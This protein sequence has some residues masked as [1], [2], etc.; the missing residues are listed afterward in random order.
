MKHHHKKSF[1][2]FMGVAGVATLTLFVAAFVWLNSRPITHTTFGVTFS[3]V[4]AQELHQDP[5]DLYEELIDDLKVRHVR[6]P[7]YWSQIETAQDEFD[8]KMPDAL[9]ALSEDRGVQLTIAVGIKVPRW[10][11]CYIPDWVKTQDVTK[12]NQA[13]LSFIEESVNRYKGSSAV[14]RWQVENEP[15]FLYGECPEIS[16]AQFKQHVDLV[17]DLDDRPI[18]VTVSG[19]MGPWLDSAQAGDILGISMYR[20]TWNDLFGYFIYPLTPEYY[21]FRA[22]L[23]KEYVSQVI[24]SE[25]QA[26]PWFSAPIDSRPLSYW[27][28]VFDVEMFEN[29]IEFVRQ[30]GLPEAYLWGAE[31]WYTLKQDGDDRLWEAARPLFQE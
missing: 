20:K 14:V 24:V 16:V 19:E 7:L 13:A 15:F 8:W 22:S 28:D 1:Y 6:L 10:P 17:R 21:F 5:L 27:Y 26:E 9:V 25:L 12:Q 31:W 29:N 11:E 4:Y 23:I 18:Q 30:A 2:L 3:W